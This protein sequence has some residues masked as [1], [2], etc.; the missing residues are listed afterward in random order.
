[1]LGDKV[2]LGFLEQFL[3]LRGALCYV[4]CFIDIERF[5][6]H[7]NKVYENTREAEHDSLSV[8]TDCDSF[9]ADSSSLCDYPDIKAT[10]TL[11]CDKMA[12]L[13]LNCDNNDTSHNSVN[14]KS[15]KLERHQQELLDDAIRIFKCYVSLEASDS[16]KCGDQVRND[17]VESICDTSKI[18][19]PNCFDCLEIYVRDVLDRDYFQAFLGSD[20][21]CKY[22]I[23]VLTSGKVVLDDILYNETALFYFMEFLEQENDRG[24][25]EFWI[26]ASNFQLQLDQQREFCDPVELQN[27]A[28][29]LY[30]KYF[31]LQAHCPLGFSDKVRFAVEQNI[32][33]E[34][35][36]TLDCFSLPLKIVEEVLRRNYLKNFRVS[37]LFYKYLSE[38]INSVN[39]CGSYSSPDSDKYAQSD[40]SSEKSFSMSSTFLAMQIPKEKKK[41]EK[42]DMNIDTR[43]L[44]DPDSLWKRNKSQKLSFGRITALGRY[45]RNFEPEPDKGAASRLKNAVRKF[46]SIEEDKNK[47]E[48]AWKVAEM[49]VKDITDVTLPEEIV[50]ES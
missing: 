16:V 9:T 36:V 43:Q 1:M 38:L 40:G 12:K 42:A 22:Q 26:A 6:L 35:G 11:Q 23:D 21:F 4:H 19:K 24:L 25:L 3:Q 37:Q 41:N 15:T 31:S 14:N 5:K 44:Y 49:I 39:S 13:D 50:F 7:A 29:V 18:V 47:E 2:A 34:N 33:G 48:M 32:C 46:V 17:I 28:V 8:S 27:D 30:D 45:E 20:C 10:A